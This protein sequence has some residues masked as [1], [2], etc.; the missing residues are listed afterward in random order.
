MGDLG[1]LIRLVAVEHRGSSGPNFP[2]QEF[3][4]GQH[5]VDKNGNP[6]KKKKKTRWLSRPTSPLESCCL[7][8]WRT[9]YEEPESILHIRV[10][11]LG[12][13]VQPGPSPV[14][15]ARAKY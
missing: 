14:R 12:R 15:Y 11:Q 10:P 8:D 5:K 1:L 4:F 7:V 6:E 2:P 13:L 9:V 3:S